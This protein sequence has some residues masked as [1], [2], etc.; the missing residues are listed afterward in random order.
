MF[1]TTRE[2]REDFRSANGKERGRKMKLGSPKPQIFVNLE[3]RISILIA[4]FHMTSLK[5]KLQNY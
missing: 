2:P 1:V 5:L 4:G 3:V